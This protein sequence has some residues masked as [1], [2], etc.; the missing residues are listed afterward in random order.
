M[1]DYLSSLPRSSQRRLPLLIGI[2]IGLLGGWLLVGNLHG[3]LGAGGRAAPRP[4]TPRA[5]LPTDEK[6]TVQLFAEASQSVV[7][8]RTIVQVERRTGL[9]TVDVENIPQGNGSG[10][11]W[12]GD[13][14]IVTN[15]HVAALAAAGRGSLEVILSGS[16][17]WQPAR[18]IGIE[19]DKDLA[20]IRVDPKG[21]DLKP[22]AVGTSRDL[23][24]GQ[25]VFAIGN[26]FGL[27]Q[28]LTTGIV[29]ALGRNIKSITGRAI[30]GVIQTDAAINPGN[31]G[32]PL[33]DSA[34]RLI[35]VNTMIYSP[36]GASAGIGFAVPVDIIN[37]VVPQLIQYGKVIRPILGIEREPENLARMIARRF[38]V[39]GGVL[40]ARVA[41]G[42]GAE[43]AGLRGRWV[44]EDGDTLAG[45]LIIKIDDTD[46]VDFDSLRDAIDKR[47]AGDTVKV[48]FLRDGERKTVKVT[49]QEAPK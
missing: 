39:A 27:H 32:G 28:T 5:D 41:S 13:G 11:I 33:L 26:P 45:D 40:I 15:F 29:S 8:V 25:K 4:I 46:I 3:M 1:S 9:F 30:E 12:D 10:F 6:A 48:T 34:G 44:D 35:G 23:Q 36:T 2:F 43:K 17:D 22:I 24:V 31:S 21:L 19:P 20:V 18:L 42:S 14:H 16:S 49:L 7:F 38:G 37:E 47:K